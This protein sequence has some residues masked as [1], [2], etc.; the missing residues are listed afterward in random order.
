MNEK[1]LRIINM[2]DVEATEV[3]W[4]WYPYIPYGKITI[5]QGDPGEGK[6]TLVL[7]LAA[8]L[9][10]GEKLPESEQASEPI[11][12]LYQSAE[13]GLSDTIKPRL[14]AANADVSRVMV[15]DETDIELSMT[16]HHLEAAIW[17]TGAKLVILDPLQAYLGSKVDMHR[18]NEVRPV[19]KNLAT[20][21]QRYDCAIVLIAHMNKS[22][23][24]KATYR[25][26]GSV[27]ITAAARSVLIVGRIKNNPTIRVMVHSKSSL[28]PEGEP[29]AF[30][31]NPETGFAFIGKYHISVDE[32]LDGT[33][34]VNKLDE[35]E[36]FLETLFANTD[37][38]P[39][40]KIT[41]QAKARN[42][43]KRTLD[44]AKKKLQ[45]QSVKI[46]SQWFWRRN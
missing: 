32:L 20:V 13:D 44:E 21:A 37:E 31:L 29:I 12:V 8:L 46:G 23:G 4:L 24:M 30:E 5:I 7:N 36:R 38:I 35:A 42:I 43:A 2:E 41:A 45:I 28:A 14:T 9:T 10:R 34:A 39:Q 3:K 27:D 15:I 19:F 1:D 25:M 17:Q 33:N 16:D 40:K 18:A 26:L 11:N 6:T 22:A